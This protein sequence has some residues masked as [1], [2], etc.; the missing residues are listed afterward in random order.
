MKTITMLLDEASNIIKEHEQKRIANGDEFNIFKITG[1]QSDEVKMCRMLAEIID[2]MGSHNQGLFFIRSFVKDVLN[3]DL[4]EHELNT[5]KVY[6]EYHT[7]ADRRIDIAIVTNKRFV[8]IE[9]KIYAEDQARQCKDYYDFAL[10]Q[11]KP[12]QSK[13]Y[14]LTLDGHLPQKSGTVGLTPLEDDGIIVG[15][16]E[17]IA[18]SFKNEI[19]SWLEKCLEEKELSEKNLLRANIE[20]FAYVLGELSGSMTKKQDEEITKLISSDS[21][22]FAAA[23]AIAE[24]VQEAKKEKLL[25][26]FSRIE[27]KLN[28]HGFPYETV[29]DKNSYKYN[30]YE[31][32]EK[33][34]GGRKTWPSLTYRYKEIDDTKE[35]WL[36]VEV[37]YNLYCG[38]VLV[39]NNENTLDASEY[40]ELIKEHI[41]TPHGFEDENWWFYW[42]YLLNDD[43]KSAPNFINTNDVM[44]K[45]FDKEYCGW[46]V[47]R[48][49]ERIIELTKEMKLK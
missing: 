42:E 10:S 34:Y 28:L 14:Y 22:K 17:I 23:C 47:D 11:N 29:N 49:A 18:I 31:A 26:L 27:F 16:D 12:E 37:D 19:Y 7:G 21:D 8:P 44:I 36:R 32:I 1:I 2:P 48:C 41:E 39:E 35:I 9:V 24:N 33:F 15:Y 43:M 5:A 6:V 38:F 46:F 3:I 40:H 25:D 30:N 20:Q 4:T 13:V 45:L